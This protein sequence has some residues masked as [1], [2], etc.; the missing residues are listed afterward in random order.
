VNHH[1]ATLALVL[2][3]ACTRSALTTVETAADQAAAEGCDLIFLPTDPALAPLCV[4]I[5]DVLAAGAA[6]GL[7]L[8]GVPDAGAPDGGSLVTAHALVVR[9]PATNARVYAWLAAHGA[10]RL[11]G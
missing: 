7:D 4:G 1:W 9:D 5:A 8:L 2:V 10:V 6:L 3:I 11:G